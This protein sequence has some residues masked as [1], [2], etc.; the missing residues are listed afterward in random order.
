MDL[1]SMDI[2]GSYPWTHTQNSTIFRFV[3][4]CLPPLLSPSFLRALAVEFGLLIFSMHL[5]VALED[6]ELRGQVD[7]V[8]QHTLG[9]LGKN[10]S[11]SDLNNL[12]FTE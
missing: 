3:L 4:L 2:H 1:R 11:R 5:E 10:P 8:A 12:I 9:Y 7:E 6:F